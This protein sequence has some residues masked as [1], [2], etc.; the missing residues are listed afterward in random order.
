[1]YEIML[2]CHPSSCRRCAEL[3]PSNGSP[4]VFSLSN[5]RNPKI[6]IVCIHDKVPS[7]TDAAASPTGAGDET[8]SEMSLILAYFGFR[9]IFKGPDP[10]LIWPQSNF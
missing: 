7:N 4:F 3:D 8:L 5:D 9:R 6:S 1:M 10:V 2:E